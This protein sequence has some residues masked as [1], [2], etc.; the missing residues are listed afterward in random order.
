MAKTIP[1]IP[2]DPLSDIVKKMTSSYFFQ[3]IILKISWTRFLKYD[4]LNLKEIRWNADI[5]SFHRTIRD[6]N[7]GKDPP[8]ASLQKCEGS[9]Y[10]NQRIYLAAGVI[11]QG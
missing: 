1:F 11:P 7:F 4:K 6:L 9:F 3:I 2:S 8:R 5:R 10:V